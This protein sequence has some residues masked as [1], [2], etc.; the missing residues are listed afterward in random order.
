MASVALQFIEE[1]TA[2]AQ[3]DSLE[4]AWDIC[5]DSIYFPNNLSILN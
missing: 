5:A 3:G 4:D 2:Y 1:F